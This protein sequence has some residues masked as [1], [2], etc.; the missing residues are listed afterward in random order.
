MAKPT[1]MYSV[2]YVDTGETVTLSKAEAVKRYGKSEW[3]HL[4]L[5][6]TVGHLGAPLPHLIV[7]PLGLSY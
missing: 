2:T 3:K 1:M 6:H 4:K 7:T 5:G